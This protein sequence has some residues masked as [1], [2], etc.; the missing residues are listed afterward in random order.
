[1]ELPPEIGSAVSTSALVATGTNVVVGNLENLI[2]NVRFLYGAVVKRPIVDRMGQDGEQP[3]VVRSEH[4]NS[5]QP[6]RMKVKPS[7]WYILVFRGLEVLRS[8]RLVRKPR[9]DLE[10]SLAEGPPPGS[11]APGNVH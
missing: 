3:W 2:R 11:G 9:E 5:F 8:L 6:R 4:F 1:M 10:E 7:E